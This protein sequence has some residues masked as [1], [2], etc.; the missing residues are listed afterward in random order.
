MKH[1][2]NIALALAAIICG[3][4]AASAEKWSCD[5]EMTKGKTYK[6]EWIV[7]GDKM[8]VPKGKGYYRVVLNNNDTLFAFLRITPKDVPQKPSSTYKNDFYNDYILIAKSTGVL[9]E[10]NDFAGDYNFGP[11]PDQ[12]MPPVVDIGHCTLEQP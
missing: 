6:E 1:L 8:F 11:N 3:S 12:W 5:M 9:T 10:F 7:S 4:S 2:R